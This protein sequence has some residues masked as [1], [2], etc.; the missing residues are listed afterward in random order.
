MWS[1]GRQEEWGQLHSAQHAFESAALIAG[2]PHE[3]ASWY[4]KTRAVIYKERRRSWEE[5]ADPEYGGTVKVKYL[6]ALNEATDLVNKAL[7]HPHRS[8][9]VWRRRLKA[10]QAR[11]RAAVADSSIALRAL[12]DE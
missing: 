9:L 2:V 8:K 11:G 7:W 10:A 3:V 12:E 6:R 4:V 5:H 1:E